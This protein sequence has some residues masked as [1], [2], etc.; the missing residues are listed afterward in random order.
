M[1]LDEGFSV[2][3]FQ[4]ISFRRNLMC[5]TKGKKQTGALLVEMEDRW[6]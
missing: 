1:I 2:F 5:H 6:N 4:V 3:W